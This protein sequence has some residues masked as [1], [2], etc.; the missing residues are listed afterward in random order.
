MERSIFRDQTR[1]KPRLGV[2][3]CRCGSRTAPT[4]NAPCVHTINL[5][6]VPTINVQNQTINAMKYDP[7]KHHRRSLRLPGYD[8]S[9]P[10]AY[11]VTICADQRQCLFG[12][13]VDGQM[14]LNQYGAIVAETYQ[15]LCQHHPYLQT[16]E[17][18]V[19]PNHFHAIMVITDKP[20][21][22]DSHGKGGSR[23]ALTTNLQ[24]PIIKQ[25]PLG[26]LIG[27]FKTVSTKKIN[28]LREAP[29]TT[30]WQR[31]YYEHIIRNQDAMDK[32]REYIVNNPLS[33]HLDQ[34]YPD[35][36]S[37]W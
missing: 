19:M 7:D 12:D 2:F 9:Q 23:T 26:R 18:I 30:L 31:N 13:V 21:S 1:H 34:L 36:P 10:G 20:N 15:W 8:Y 29:G 5:P 6:C 22:D 37:K 3:R 33:W 25:K 27:A 17:W 16:D 24:N 28:I 4:I 35:N 11:F 32:I 14:G